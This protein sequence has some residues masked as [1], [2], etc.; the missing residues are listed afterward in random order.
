MELIVGIVFILVVVI[1]TIYF[2]GDT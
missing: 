2:F 1:R